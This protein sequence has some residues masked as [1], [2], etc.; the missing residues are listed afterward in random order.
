MSN[1]HG[2]VE[3]GRRCRGGV[4]AVAA[5]G[6][7]RRMEDRL[8]DHR[9]TGCH[10]KTEETMAECEADHAQR[11]RE[12]DQKVDLGNGSACCAMSD[13][14]ERHDLDRGHHRTRA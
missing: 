8:G 9:Y 11:R 2:C 5:T 10:M 7:E 6:G 3:A 13:G 4:S 1:D 14:A 12:R